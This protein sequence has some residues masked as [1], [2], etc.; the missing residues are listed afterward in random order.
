M[1]K[2]SILR[3]FLMNLC[4]NNFVKTKNAFRPPPRVRKALKSKAQPPIVSTHTLYFSQKYM[5]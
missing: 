5:I 4:Y 2:S 1:K 3:D